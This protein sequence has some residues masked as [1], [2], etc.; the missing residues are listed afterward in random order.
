LVECGFVLPEDED[1]KAE[2][3]E[4]DGDL[5]WLNINRRGELWINTKEK[6]RAVF[7]AVKGQRHVVEEEPAKPAQAAASSA[8][9]GR[10]RS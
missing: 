6:P 8:L 1:S 9:S 7:R 4:Y 2:Y 10:T 5:Y 3:L